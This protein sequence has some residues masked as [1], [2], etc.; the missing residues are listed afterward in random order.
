MVVKFAEQ[1]EPTAYPRRTPVDTFEGGLAVAETM[2]SFKPSKRPTGR[3]SRSQSGYERG[4]AV[5][6]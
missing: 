6:P 4:G 2:P 5:S 3:L 1:N